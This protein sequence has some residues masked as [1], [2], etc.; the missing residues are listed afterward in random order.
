MSSQGTLWAVEATGLEKTFGAVHAVAG[1][2]LAIRPGEVVAFLGPNGAGKTTTIDMLLGLAVPTTGSAE[3]FGLEP[4]RAVDRGLV[5]AVLQT[6]G[7]LKDLSVRETVELTGSLFSHTRGVQECL[8]RAGIAGIAGRRVNKCS[9]GQQQ[10]LRFAMAL[11]SDPSLIVFDEPTTGMDVTGRRDFWAAIRED[12]AGGCTVL[13]A[14]HYLEEA[15]R[16]ADRVILM[17]AGRIVAD[18][19][20]GELRAMAAGRM[21]R[22]TWPGATDADLAAVPAHDGAQRQ[23]DQVAFRALDS[24]AVARHLLTA[25]SARDL[26]ITSHGLEDAFMALTAGDAGTAREPGRAFSKEGSTR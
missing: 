4:R 25:T 8:D 13:F 18:G 21:V 10:R 24:D 9:G 7:L 22:A 23:G 1:V 14:T 6:G 16:Y 2:S 5:S 3:L 17:D 19:T 12:A 11:I 26:A 20:P 15:E